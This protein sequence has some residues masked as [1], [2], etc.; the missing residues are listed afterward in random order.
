MATAGPNSP[1]SVVNVAASG[2]PAWTLPAN[3]EALDGVYASAAITSIG[4]QLTCTGYGFSIPGGATIN[5]IQFDTY[6]FKTGT[7]GARD[8][9][10]FAIKGGVVG[11]TNRAALVA[12]TGTLTDQVYGGVSDLW[13]L[14]WA[15]SDINAS[16]F[17]IA[18][19]TSHTGTFKQ[20]STQFV[21]YISCTIYYTT[22][23]GVVAHQTKVM[24]AVNRASTY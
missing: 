7:G 2:S 10:V 22:A 1:T 21:D 16:N 23:S 8:F 11:T 5:G 24:Q 12:F 14:T 20:P 18:Y 6:R 9:Q 4:Q 13:G 17:G 15:A 19:Q 3:A